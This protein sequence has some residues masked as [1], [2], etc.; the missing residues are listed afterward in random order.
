MPPTPL[1]HRKLDT[2]YL[3]FITFHLINLFCVD[4]VSLYPPAW[5]PTA[6]LDLRAWYI[7]TYDD[8]YFTA[9][10]AWFMLYTYIE[11]IYHLPF[12]IW[13]IPAI[14]HNDPLVPLH[15]FIF[16]LEAGLTTATCIADILS[17]DD[18]PYNK[19]FDLMTLYGPYLV[20]SMIMGVDMFF[21]LSKTVTTST[22]KAK[23]S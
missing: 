2:L 9:P 3:A 22:G 5:T 21:R 8:R 10:T 14:V 19:K 1:V 20:L 4:F 23:R 15:L 17:W 18:F 7:K 16:A 6:L 12:T 13:A 11:V